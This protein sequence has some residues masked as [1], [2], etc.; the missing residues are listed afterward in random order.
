MKIENLPPR[1]QPK[2]IFK[3]SYLFIKKKEEKKSTKKN[4][5]EFLKITSKDVIR[6]KKR[7]R[8][9]KM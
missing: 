9:M 7:E 6:K 3:N 8:A 2:K 1:N 4:V 5:F